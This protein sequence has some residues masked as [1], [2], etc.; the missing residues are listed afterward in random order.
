M[1]SSSLQT[2]ANKSAG[3]NPA[4]QAFPLEDDTQSISNPSLVVLT[5]TLPA[6]DIGA[7]TS[8]IPAIAASTTLGYSQAVTISGSAIESSAAMDTESASTVAIASSSRISKFI[9]QSTAMTGPTAATG[10]TYTTKLVANP[11]AVIKP[12]VGT[13]ITFGQPLSTTKASE[14]GMSTS[15]P[16]AVIKP[17]VGTQITFGQ[18]LST[19]KASEEGISTSSS[20]L[21]PSSTSSAKNPDSPFFNFLHSLGSSPASIALTVLVCAGILALLC[22]TVAFFFRRSRRRYRRGIVGESGDRGEGK[23]SDVASCYSD[24]PAMTQAL[25]R[26]MHRQASDGE[27]LMAMQFDDFR[28]E[29]EDPQN[30]RTSCVPFQETSPMNTSLV[31]QFVGNRASLLDPFFSQYLNIHQPKGYIATEDI[32]DLNE[33][34]KSP[35]ARS[36]YF[37]SFSSPAK[38]DTI[39]PVPLNA[40]LAAGDIGSSSYLVPPRP[41]RPASLSSSFQLAMEEHLSEDLA[42]ANPMGEALTAAVSLLGGLPSPSYD[43]EKADAFTTLPLIIQPRSSSRWGSFASNASLGAPDRRLQQQMPSRFSMTTMATSSPTPT[44]FSGSVYADWQIRSV[45]RAS[46]TAPKRAPELV[47][48]RTPNPPDTNTIRDRDLHGMAMYQ[49]MAIPVIRR[50]R[51]DSEVDSIGT[52]STMPFAFSVPITTDSLS[53]PPRRPTYGRYESTRSVMTM[54]DSVYSQNDGE[55]DEN[56]QTSLEEQKAMVDLIKKRRAAAQAAR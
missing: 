41:I 39:L 20:A 54:A 45:L 47:Q 46:M 30:E 42:E 33:S 12:V 29:K 24:D 48:Q 35:T 14:E 2:V 51:S 44:V 1:S 49:N 55:D 11:S 53:S 36:A 31:Q 3:S 22:A 23:Y 7:I 6:S 50:E 10:A 26:Q 43:E 5:I 34:R 56:W 40:A 13:Q 8:A 17:V 4:S 21:S 37:G 38:N 32:V 15:Y 16:S 27:Y 52:Q 25:P 28:S 9:A 19:T 18:P